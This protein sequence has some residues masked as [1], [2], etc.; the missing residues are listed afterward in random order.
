MDIKPSQSKTNTDKF[1]FFFAAEN[2][3][4]IL[5]ARDGLSVNNQSPPVPVR[6]PEA[7]SYNSHGSSVQE[8]PSERESPAN[9][10]RVLNL[11]DGG[12]RPRKVD[13][14]PRCVAALTTPSPS[15]SRLPEHAQH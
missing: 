14:W 2:L 5:Q 3:I 6:G 15:L 4:T 7:C 8:S 1:L 10:V 11:A 13:T 9:S 12:V